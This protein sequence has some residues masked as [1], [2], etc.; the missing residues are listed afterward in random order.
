LARAE[1]ARFYGWQ[2]EEIMN[3]EVKTFN[4]YHSAIKVLSAKEELSSI[5]VVSYPHRKQNATKEHVSRL[6]KILSPYMKKKSLDD[7]MGGF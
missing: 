3:M 2:H 6:R 4:E 7:V 5:E 1:V